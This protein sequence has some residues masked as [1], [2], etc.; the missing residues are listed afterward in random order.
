MSVRLFGAIGAL[1]DVPPDD[2]W[3]TDAERDVL[4]GLHL[5]RRR[6]D[7]RLG[8]WTARSAVAA[9]TGHTDAPPSE[10]Q[11]L[12]DED[13]APRAAINGYRRPISLSISHRAGRAFCVAAD[14][15][16]ALG[17]DVEL[18]ESRSDAFIR[19]YFTEGERSL[20]LAAEPGERPLLANLVWAAKEAALKGL[21]TGLRADTRSVVV[22][23]IGE[24]A[25]SWA[26]LL[27]GVRDRAEDWPGWWRYQDGFLYTV[28][29][30][31][32]TEWASP[33][34]G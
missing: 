10:I 16:L 29:A 26:P 27:I 6:D 34:T 30:D 32:P 18:I 22:G 33:V 28:A 13:G 2:E 12:A 17:C 14:A 7:W 15:D 5:S 8:R 3:L 4:A 19:D 9:A 11:V 23:W 20:V 21:R 31:R 24:G 25:G 1:A